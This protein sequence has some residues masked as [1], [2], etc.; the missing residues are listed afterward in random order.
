MERTITG[1]H[2]DEAGDWV[3]ELDCHHN[4]HVRNRPPFT[5]RPWVESE[6]GRAAHVGA[7]LDCLLCDRLEMPSHLVPYKRTP[8]FSADTV[9]AGLL[10][11]HSTRCGVWG[12]I[13]VFKGR[14]RY[15][16]E[17]PE[18]SAIE[19]AAGHSAN[20]APQMLH[21]VKPLGEVEFCVEFFHP[22][23]ASGNESLR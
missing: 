6:S 23:D 15:T 7:K 8:M 1:F 13:S 17:Q 19:I 20:I 22:G 4:Q 2:Q 5:V 18:R 21:A 9:P 16:V 11:Q 10:R 3:A 12:R 14:L